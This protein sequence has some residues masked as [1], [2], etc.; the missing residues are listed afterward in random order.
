M[1]R[2]GGKGQC[3]QPTAKGIEQA[4]SRRVERLVAVDAVINDITRDVDQHTVRRRALIDID[5]GG[6]R[7]P[8]GPRVRGSGP[9]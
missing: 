2:T 4:V 7:S 9:V 8:I 3:Q 5:V 1:P 6:H